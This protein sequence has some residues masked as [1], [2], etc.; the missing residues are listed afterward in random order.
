ME[1][2]RDRLTNSVNVTKVGELC[3]GIKDKDREGINNI[4][5]IGDR[6]R[7]RALAFL[8]FG[9]RV[10]SFRGVFVVALLNGRTGIRDAGENGDFLRRWQDWGKPK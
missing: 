6:N 3:H 9:S 1:E 7:E 8:K 2:I 10:T 5:K 4:C